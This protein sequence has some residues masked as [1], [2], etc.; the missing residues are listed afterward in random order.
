MFVGLILGL[1]E[2]VFERNAYIGGEARF[3]I[4]AYIVDSTLYN[5]VCIGT[6][7]GFGVA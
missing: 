7:D 2:A 4:L 5:K 6:V 1:I 3:E